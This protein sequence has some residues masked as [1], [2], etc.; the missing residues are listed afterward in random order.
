MTS[1]NKTP[2]LAGLSPEQI[3]ES[4]IRQGEANSLARINE[5]LKGETPSI[6]SFAPSN[7]P[8]FEEIKENLNKLTS[9]GQ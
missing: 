6:D 1:I 9:K 5:V 4:G 2:S 8:A 7:R 3:Y